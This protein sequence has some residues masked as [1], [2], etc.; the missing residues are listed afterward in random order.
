M[1]PVI[2]RRR[3]FV[4][5]LIVVAAIVTRHWSTARSHAAETP[6]DAAQLTKSLD[7][8]SLELRL[9]CLNS[10]SIDPQPSLSGKVEI[11]ASA[12]SQEE[13]DRLEFTGGAVAHI[14]YK[15]DCIRYKADHEPSLVLTI[16]VP[17]ATP[18]D[19]QDSGSGD[20]HIGAVGAAL[21]LQLSGSGDIEAAQATDLDLRISGSSDVKLDRLDGPGKIDV[22]GSGDVSIDRGTMPS[23]AVELRGSGAVEIGDATIETLTASTTGSGD[24]SVDGTVKDATLTTSGSGDI[25][26][27]KATGEVHSHRSGSG[28]IH[29]GS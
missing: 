7:G 13:L 17:P 19:L 10:A 29:I 5:G 15:G 12:R 6:A 24:I 3:L 27:G 14:E 21:K 2:L 18:I 25:T 4:F 20:Y 22:S 1:H 26:L 23:L 8:T 28:E 16:K 9:S 11:A